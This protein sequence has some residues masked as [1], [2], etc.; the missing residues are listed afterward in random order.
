MEHKICEYGCNK[1]ANYQFKNKKWCCSNFLSKC[2]GMRKKNS[3]NLKGIERPWLINNKHGKGRVS[4]NL[5]LTKETDIRIKKQSDLKKGKSY[6]GRPH[7]EETKRKLSETAKKLKY[8]GYRKGS[9]RGKK[10]IYKEYYFDSSWEFYW[11]VYN[12]DHNIFFKR[13][14]VGYT[15]YFDGKEKKYYP[16]FILSDNSI[17]EVKGYS[18]KE[19]D[20]KMK[21]LE[22]NNIKYEIID[23]HK[24][25]PYIKYVDSTYGKNYVDLFLNKNRVKIQKVTKKVKPILSNDEI[26]KLGQDCN[27]FNEIKNKVPKT[28]GIPTTDRLIKLFPNIKYIKKIKNKNPKKRMSKEELFEFRIKSRKVIRPTKEE[29]INLLKNIS[30][31]DIGKRYNVSDNCIRKWCKIYG[32]NSK[33]YSP[34]SHKS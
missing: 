7:T 34:F 6:I 25:I 17:V 27:T 5:G 2:E 9:G 8:G 24:I 33:E 15:Y 16:D 10:G 12:L 14:S 20:A 23:K 26:L 29:L 19:V 18:T 30:V 28:F 1:I 22:F 32:F 4:W 3:L 11:I 13:N 31:V 21:T